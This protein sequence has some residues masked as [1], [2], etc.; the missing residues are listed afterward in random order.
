MYRRALIHFSINPAAK[1]DSWALNLKGD[2]SSSE[3]EPLG[4]GL[5][6]VRRREEVAADADPGPNHRLPTWPCI[7]EYLS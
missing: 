4:P 3:S 5:A 7:V 1:S 6:N 2:L